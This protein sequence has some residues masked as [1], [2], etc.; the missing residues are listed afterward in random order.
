[1]EPANRDLPAAGSS[2]WSRTPLSVRNVTH[3]KWK[4]A[5]AIAGL[6][7]AIM[8]ILM[9]IGFLQS[10]KV[11]ATNIYSQLDFD[12]VLISREYA[13][14]Y[15]SNTISID[16]LYQARSITGATRAFPLY[17]AM[18]LWRCPPKILTPKSVDDSS[19][20]T[21]H[22]E[23]DLEIDDDKK[24]H[25]RALCVLGF[26]LDENPFLP[27]IRDDIDAHLTQLAKPGTVLMDRKSHPD[28][29][30]SKRDLYHEWELG[31][32]KVEIVGGVTLGAG[33]AADAT[34]ICSAESF[35]RFIPW[36]SLDQPSIGLLTFPKG[37][38]IDDMVKLLNEQLPPDVEALTRAQIWDRERH[39]WINNT[40]TGL[41]FGF[42][43][44]VSLCVGTVVIY[45]VLA[46]DIANHFAEYAT[47]KAMGY[48]NMYLSRIV[49][50]QAALYAVLSFVPA[51][52][53]AAILYRVVALIANI[54][55]ILT[56]G[57][58][59]FVFVSTLLMSF[60]SALL[61]MRRVWAADPAELF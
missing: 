26:D 38:K 53:A 27:P 25:P 41:L 8:L 19:P 49:L 55:M 24:S 50:E 2:P 59:T 46:N 17:E 14:F 7:F 3:E 9:Q 13:Q 22:Y 23:T 37:S 4:S 18:N 32:R 31:K 21:N 43:V 30:W 1:M 39:Y 44:F 56:I 54:P 42:G 15:D 60:L 36:A 58:V 10:V 6:G 35:A 48:N 47:L 11:T 33:F 45:Q 51:L 12:A 28:F 52:V 5:T 20:D 29:G 57:N 61:T 16:R 40:A 34:V